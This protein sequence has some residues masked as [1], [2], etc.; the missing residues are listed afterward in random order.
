MTKISSLQKISPCLWFDNNAEEAVQFYT[1]VFKS[2]SIG[3]IGRYGENDRLPEGTA[4]MIDFNLEGQNFKALN[5]GPM[6]KFSEAI[7]MMIHC[8]DQEEIDYYWD[9]LLEGGME[10][11]CGWL[12]DKYGLSR[13]VIPKS[14]GKLMSGDPQKS[15]NVMKEV[16]KMIKIDLPTLE[17]AYNQ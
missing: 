13:Q 12:K 11:Q 3:Q 7:S 1:S 15:A 9:R 8:E 6:F 14:I 4:L 5:G 17:R 2:S 10:Q 16:M